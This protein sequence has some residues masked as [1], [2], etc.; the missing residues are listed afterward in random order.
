MQPGGPPFQGPYGGPPPPPPPPPPPGPPPVGPH[1][2]YSSGWAPWPA[3]GPTHPTQPPGRDAA[4]GPGAGAVVIDVGG[5]A[6][7]QGIV[8]AVVSGLI[9]LLAIVAG[10]AGAV[11]GGGE[12]VAIVIGVL[13]LVPPLLLLGL[14]KQLLRPRR[15]VFEAAGIR[16]DDPQ[17]KPW[18]VGWHELAAVAISKHSAIQLPQTT[19]E[20]IAGATTE[21]LLG[22]RA[23]VRLDLYPA[24]PG[25]P[26][27]HPQMAHLWGRQEVTN[28]YR[29]PLGANVR[30][31]PL[32]AQAMVRFAPSIYRG[33]VATRGAMGLT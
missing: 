18:A 24:D 31:I 2:G 17:G 7:R 15:L 11:D 23:H 6:A 5:T 28:G 25:F 13:F 30:F 4:Y 32:I 3:G 27:R 16:W 19:S 22:E 1:P 12:A 14:S 26:G 20:R 33:V 9:G 21:K 10:L 29:L 8:G